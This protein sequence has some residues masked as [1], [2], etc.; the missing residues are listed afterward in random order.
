MV[1]DDPIELPAS[2]K[3]RGVLMI[4]I[5]VVVGLLIGGGAVYLLVSGTAEAPTDAG[6]T[7][8]AAAPDE[9]APDLPKVDLLVVPVRRFAVPLID[10]DGDVLGYMWVDLAFEVDGPDHQSYVAARIPELRDAFLRDLNARQTTQK[11]KP[12]ALDFELLRER[13]DAVSKQ[14][15]GP[16]RVLRVRITNAQRV[17]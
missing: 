7:D 6:Q 14:V 13:L 9:A 15:M 5:G 10:H 4:I 2:G 16:E 8:A 11:D 12:G 1:D 17:P 3:R